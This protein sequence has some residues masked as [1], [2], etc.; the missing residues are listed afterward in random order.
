MAPLSFLLWSQSM[1]AKQLL[2]ALA[3]L[4]LSTPAWAQQ[5]STD[6][7]AVVAVVDGVAVHRSELEEVARGLPEQ[8]RQMP[9][10]AL[11][12]ILLDRV[13]DFRLLANEAE[14]LDVADDPAVETALARA[15]AD[16]LRDALVQQRIREE[17]TQDKLRERYEGLKQ[18][19]D[20]AKD[21]VHAR[22][23]LTE[24]EEE[25]RAV[26]V[27]LQGGAD[28]AALAA[29]RSVGPSA[30]G[31]GDLGF[32][33]REQMVPEF[34]EAAFALEPGEITTEPVQ[35]QFG[36]HVIMVL[37]RRTAEPTFAESE[38]QLRQELAREI[39][40][41]LVADLREDAEIERFNLDGT[42]LQAAPQAPGAG[43]A[44]PEAGEATPET[45]DA[46][47]ESE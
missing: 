16:V 36:W 10:Q 11:Y 39:V 38:P 19:E 14:R 24:S 40:T 22:H 28:F 26:I 5:P 29:E 20:F 41:A 27:E 8:F 35:T 47:P 15:R 34:A 25:A 6:E 45:G 31:G 33:R 13:I 30:E 2:A 1:W 12:G 21:E 43:D 7:D 46:A 17:T 23:I 4:L 9:L 3:I 44:S 32:F 37:D 18:S 42:P